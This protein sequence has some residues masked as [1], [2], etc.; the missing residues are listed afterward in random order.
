[1]Q[2]LA[3]KHTVM[4]IK[5]LAQIARKGERE[6]SRVAAATALLDRG[7]GRP[8]QAIDLRMLLDKK[9]TELSA[10]ELALVEQ[11]LLAIGSVQEPEPE[12]EESMQCLN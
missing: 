4:A 10:Q 8:P 7:Y 11:H 2:E 6:A 1:V 9:L 12:A 3:Q 5:V